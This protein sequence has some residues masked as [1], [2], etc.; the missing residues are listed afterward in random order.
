MTSRRLQQ[1][2]R[3]SS[4]WLSTSEE[5]SQCGQSWQTR[6]LAGRGKGDGLSTSFGARFSSIRFPLFVLA[7]IGVAAV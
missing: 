6:S 3:E 5:A 1:K 7:F 4:Q 2:F